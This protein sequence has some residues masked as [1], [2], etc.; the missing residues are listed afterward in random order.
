M[1][2][3]LISH[4]GHLFQCLF[5]FVEINRRLFDPASPPPFE[6]HF[7]TSVL[8]PFKNLKPLVDA[9]FQP[10]DFVCQL[11]DQLA[12]RFQTPFTAL[13][14]NR[15]LLKT[16]PQLIADAFTGLREIII[17]NNAIILRARPVVKVLYLSLCDLKELF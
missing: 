4:F 11:E 17:G 9:V 8:L 7:I 16:G 12:L 14:K 2:L 6:I 1:L 13:D 3:L 15:H 5:S 10:G